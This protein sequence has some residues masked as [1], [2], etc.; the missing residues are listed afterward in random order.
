M[1]K[2]LMHKISFMALMVV[3]IF[4]LTLKAINAE[5]GYFLKDLD[6]ELL[7]QCLTERFRADR[8]PVTIVN[9]EKC[10]HKINKPCF[11]IQ[12]E[13]NLKIT[14]PPWEEYLIDCGT[15]ITSGKTSQFG[16]WDVKLK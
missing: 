13:A 10:I 15:L 16:M 12:N 7:A 2:I 6:Q 11:L 8:Y 4:S 14:L 3:C 1:T 5:E 9:S